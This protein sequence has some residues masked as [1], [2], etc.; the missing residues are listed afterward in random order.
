MRDTPGVQAVLAECAKLVNTKTRQ[1]S[2]PARPVQQL[3]TLRPLRQRMRRNALRALRTMTPPLTAIIFQTA[4][5][6]AS[7]VCSR[8]FQ[9]LSAASVLQENSLPTFHAGT[10]ALIVSEARIHRTLAPHASPALLSP[11]HQQQVRTFQNVHARWGT[12]TQS[13]ELPALRVNPAHT[14]KPMD[15]LPAHHVLPAPTVLC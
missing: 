6:C 2:H 1:A 9:K 10:R 14:R 13:Q 3:S 7:Q 8:T 12:H 15:Q 11:R 4:R 5:C